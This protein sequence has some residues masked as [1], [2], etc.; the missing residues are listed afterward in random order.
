LHPYF[1][2]LGCDTVG[3][4]C[5]TEQKKIEVPNML[6]IWHFPLILGVVF[7]QTGPGHQHVSTPSRLAVAPRVLTHPL[8]WKETPKPEEKKKNID[9]KKHTHTHTNNGPYGN[10]VR[11]LRMKDC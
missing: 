5:L 9:G 6:T 4:G 7:H 11:N 3:K 2:K 10:E 1:I 8:G